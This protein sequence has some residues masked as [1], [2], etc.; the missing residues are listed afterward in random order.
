MVAIRNWN[1]RMADLWWTFILFRICEATMTPEKTKQ[2]QTALLKYNEMARKILA[3]E[4]CCDSNEVAEC[5]KR[6]EEA[7]AVGVVGRS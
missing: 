4:A 2:M 6:G 1:C 7:L 5:L 3:T